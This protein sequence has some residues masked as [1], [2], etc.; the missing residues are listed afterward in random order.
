MKR[1]IFP[2]FILVLSIF[3]ATG[4]PAGEYEYR[5]VEKQFQNFITCE[6]TRTDAVNHFKGKPFQITMIDLYSV[7]RESGVLICTGAVQCAVDESYQTLYA[8][9]GIREIFGTEQ[10]VYYTIRKKDFRILLTE[11]ARS[12][13]KERCPWSE[14]WIDTD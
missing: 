14:F 1:F 8:A 6:M 13:Y 4:L 10:V 2:L 3:I 7:Q 11:L 12:P 9:V 5:V